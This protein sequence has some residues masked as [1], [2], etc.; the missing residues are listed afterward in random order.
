[1][2]RPPARELRR[3]TF[4]KGMMARGDEWDEVT[5]GNISAHGMMI[6]CLHPPLVGDRVTVRRRG[7]G[8]HG[9][10]QWVH[11]RRFGLLCESEIDQDAF[12]ADSAAS[13]APQVAPGAMQGPRV[14]DKLW[15]WRR[16]T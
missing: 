15:H 13:A 5:I 1:M 14:T 3:I 11:G 8:A 7:A 2:A 9:V 10:V 6:K 16:P 4:V 12:V